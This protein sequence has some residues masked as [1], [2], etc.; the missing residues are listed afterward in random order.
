M[1]TH[2]NMVANALQCKAWHEQVKIEH[3]TYIVALPLYHIFS[4]TANCLLYM[5]VGGYG[6]LIPNP[7]DFPS[8]VKELRRHRPNILNG[9]NTLFNALMNTPGFERVDFSKLVATVGGGM[10]V[11]ATVAERW[12]KVTGC[13]LTQGWG[14]TETSPVA[15]VNKL[16]DVPFNGSIGLPLPSTE[17]SI[18]NDAGDDVGIDVAGELCV[19]GP[20]VMRGYWQREDETALVM[21][22][23]GFI[24]TGD[25]GRM[26]KQGYVYIEDRKKDMITVSGFKVYPNEV[27]AVAA[28]HPKVFEAAAIGVP[29]ERSGESV[30][31]YVVA[32]DKS[33]TEEELVKF[34]RE[35]L[36][37]YKVPR[38]VHFRESLPKT[39][40]GKILR[41]ALRDG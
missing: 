2:R 19:R 16:I 36:T 9:V 13:P 20:Q 1:L 26:D 31:L 29:D 24:R 30:A 4:L 35:S 33:L 14:L 5:L 3:A 37:S 8:F 28:Q 15:A 6:V 39:N 27:E 12:R 17:I 25:I 22:P 38:H 34:M 7:R 10:A 23:D 40:V 11:Q 32:K 21:L 18:R 41:R